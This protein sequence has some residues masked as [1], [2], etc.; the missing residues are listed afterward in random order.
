RGAR[1]ARAEGEAAVPDPRG[2][3]LD[4]DAGEGGGE[5]ED[6]RF[7]ARRHRPRLEEVAGVVE[8]QGR[9]RLDRRQRTGGGEGLAELR[10][11]GAGGR[12]A[13]EG[14]A[15]EVAEDAGEGALR[16][17]EE[18]GEGGDRAAVRRAL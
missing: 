9:P 15:P 1:R 14:L 3:A 4:G 10:R 2:V 12:R 7:V 8:L 5:V 13:V 17:G 6:R 18:H 16:A 11:Q